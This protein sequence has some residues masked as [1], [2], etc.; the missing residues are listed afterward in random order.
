ML[1]IPTE[2]AVLILCQVFAG[3][4]SESVPSSITGFAHRRPRADSTASFTYFQG[5]D[6]SPEWPEDEVIDDDSDEDFDS[7]KLSTAELDAR[8]LSSKARISS[9]C[10]ARSMEDPLLYRHGSTRTD[11]SRTGREA[12]L[13]QKIYVVTEDLTIVVAGFATR[14]FGFVLYLALCYVTLGIGFLVLRW[15]PRWR[16]RLIG[17]PRPLKDCAWVVTEVR[18]LSE[19]RISMV[20]LKSRRING[21]NLLSKTLSNLIMGIPSPLYLDQR[22]KS[23]LEAMMRTMMIL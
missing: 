3:P 8:S 6:E 5:H 12:R 21:V 9:E 14:P 17:S 4:V 22:K 23:K 19:D 7:R 16:V 1:I 13:N 15:L 18:L 20:P 11:G 2:N 10:S